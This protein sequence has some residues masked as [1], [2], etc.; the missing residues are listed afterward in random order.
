[1]YTTD[2][3]DP[4][5]TES[6]TLSESMAVHLHAPPPPCCSCRTHYLTTTV[7]ALDMTPQARMMLSV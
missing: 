5:K 7:Y 6:F 4:D 1:M 2:F 3:L